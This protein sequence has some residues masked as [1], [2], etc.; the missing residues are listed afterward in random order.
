[1]Q[2][3]YRLTLQFI[4]IVACILVVALLFIHFQFKKNIE[5]EFYENLRSKAMMTAEMVVGKF[6]GEM[7]PE[8]LAEE[9]G[10]RLSGAYT[11]N[12]SIYNSDGKLIYSFNPL[13]GRINNSTI[14]DIQ[15][16][17][18]KCFEN[19][20]F[21]AIGILYANRAGDR[22]VVVA[23]AVFNP[24]HLHNLTRILLWVFFISI[25]LVA[26]GGWFFARQALAPVS[27]IMNQV[28]E[29]LPSN[30][31][32]RL[33]HDGQSDE[34]SRLVITF[35]KMLDRVERAF[36]VQKMFLSNISHELKNP[37]NVIVSQIEVSLD[38]D[39]SGDE[40][41]QT[42]SSVLSDV[43]ELN[44][45]ADM[46][47]Q[48]ARINSEKPAIQFQPVRIDELIWQAK[49][50]LLKSNPDYKICFE[51]A[52]LPENEEK[53]TVRANEQLLKT[54]LIN[55]LDNGCKFS[56]DRSVKARLSFSNK[57]VPT[58]EIQDNGPGVREEETRFL[59][60][61]FY[62]SPGTASV[63]GSGIGLSLVDS[64]MKLH[65]IHLGLAS[66]QGFGSTFSLTFPE[67]PLN[68]A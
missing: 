34:L 4:L 13:P 61:P 33:E 63:A 5:T 26:A 16:S 3:R 38:Q 23:E 6:A 55:L 24:V 12:I 30:L 20:R 27:R 9:T 21:K 1:M 45:A 59:F 22:F 8:L 48:M 54:A 51:V 49:A 37:L 43:K 57:G 19:G 17:R 56:P 46:L 52:N 44:Q 25:S 7:P 2:I 58:V 39:R 36:K 64:I 47:M 11:E 35:N 60:E 28:D 62:R 31:Q 65:H 29:L 67:E 10:N 32:H 41:R 15:S 68:A 40:Y 53:L 18:E 14:R 42:L 66:R 50:A